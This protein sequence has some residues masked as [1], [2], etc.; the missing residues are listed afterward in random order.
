MSVWRLALCWNPST[1]SLLQTTNSKLD[2]IMASQNVLLL[3]CVCGTPSTPR[4]VSPNCSAQRRI[5]TLPPSEALKMGS[6]GPPHSCI[7]LAISMACASGTGKYN[8]AEFVA[9][10]LDLLQ[11]SIHNPVTP[12]LWGIPLHCLNAYLSQDAAKRLLASESPLA[13]QIRSVVPKII[14]AI[15]KDR[16]LLKIQGAL[17][18][19]IRNTVAMFLKSLYVISPLKRYLS[20]AL[21]KLNPTYSPLVETFTATNP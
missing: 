6:E 5:A 7:T 21:C 1:S 13:A 8:E 14:D 12:G 19:V 11:R 10:S 20:S 9:F 2:S 4:G 15:W 17:E 16:N 3:Q 18:D